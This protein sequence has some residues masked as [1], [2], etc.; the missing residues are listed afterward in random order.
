MEKKH[1]PKKATSISENNDKQTHLDQAI[2]KARSSLLSDQHEDGYWFYELEAD[3]TIP[4]EYIMMM[5]YMDEID[6]ELQE[7][8]AVYLRRHQNEAGGWPLYYGGKSDLSC[9][10][11]AYYAL[12]MAGDD[13]DAP[14][15]TKARELILS[16]GGAAKSNVFTRIALAL[17]EQIPWRAV[18]FIPVE[19]MTFPDWFPLHL[20]KVSYWSRTV[21]VP[22]FILYS[23]RAKARNPHNVGVQELFLVQPE[24]ED[25]YF[26]IRSMTNR[27][28]FGLERIGLKLEPYIPNRFREHAIKKAEEWFVARLNGEDGLGA[29]FPAM[30][31]AY[32]AL[33]LL[34]YPED[35]P[36]RKTAKKALQK[37]LVV[38][39]DEAYC[40]P[41]L[42]PIWDTILSAGAI[43]E[44]G[45]ADQDQEQALVNATEWLANKQLTDEPGDWRNDRPDLQGGSWPFQFRNDYYPD[46]DDTAFAAFVLHSIDSEKYKDNILRA[47]RWLKGMQSSNGGFAAFEYDNTYY[48]LNEIPFADHGALLDPPTADVSARCAM[49]FGQ[50]EN[51]YPEFREPLNR[52]LDYLFEVQEEDGSWFGRWGTNYIYGTWSVLIAC[53]SA[54]IPP[55]E[56]EI[57]RAVAWLKRKQREDGGWGEDN[58]SYHD[59]ET[60]GEAD[61]STSFQ[62]AWAVMGLIAA[63]EVDSEA[64]R[65]GIDFLLSTQ[66][67]DGFWS[68]PE[69][70]A[71]GFPRVFYLKYHGYTKF[72]PLWALAKY[73]RKIDDEKLI[74]NV[75]DKT[76]K[77]KIGIVVALPRELQTLGNHHKAGSEIIHHSERIL[78]GQSGVGAKNA[79]KAAER[80]I[81]HGA[82]ILI[83]WG[84]ATA[85]TPDIA[86]GTI[87]IPDKVLTTEQDIFET[88]RRLR[89]HL[90][91]ELPLDGMF[92]HDTICETD[93]ILANTSQKTTLAARTNARIADM[94]T[95]AVARVAK[96][97]D[98]PFLAIRSV[99]DSAEMQIPRA[100][101][102]NVNDGTPNTLGILSDAILEPKDWL[103]MISLSYNF[104]KAQKSLSKMAQIIL[105]Y[106][107]RQADNIKLQK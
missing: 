36:H 16:M 62:T 4:A 24:K 40:Q 86:P 7:K 66:E 51:E 12:K 14:H 88:D 84:T 96:E 97:H 22:L 87:A 8:I 100:I 32:E 65:R 81:N 53:E 70:T 91:N 20:Q 93:E 5:H 45:I 43:Q 23:L 89:E 3:C 95:A 26:K 50:L 41:C 71:P 44:T 19:I 94:E 77:N 33:D 61:R 85:L 31:N 34:G 29:I 79:K 58:W 54:D 52:C 21:M 30:V 104:N 75:Q 37:L 1:S 27:F 74:S 15:M 42:S 80:L 105:P 47:A 106:L 6:E 103:P 46:L 63:G 60:R 56:P 39:E 64:V 72:F 90:F 38:R 55:E 9:S 73:Q 17:F 48:Y 10:V 68:D 76:S 78:I 13:I 99:S 107:N 67:E 101:K 28:I 49:L 59:P 11:K 2:K 98:I 57:Q 35:H 83:S 92:V 25:D 18:P 82:N 102:N 69:F